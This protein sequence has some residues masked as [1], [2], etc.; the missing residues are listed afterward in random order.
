MGKNERIRMKAATAS[1]QWQQWA[2]GWG[3][4]GYQR[5]TYAS[6]SGEEL[7][8]YLYYRTPNSIIE[9]PEGTEVDFSQRF[10]NYPSTEWSSEY[11]LALLHVLQDPS[12]RVLVAYGSG[13]GTERNQLAD[14]IPGAKF[15]VLPFGCAKRQVAKT[16]SEDAGLRIDIPGIGKCSAYPACPVMCDG[17]PKYALWTYAEHYDS[18]EDSFAYLLVAEEVGRT[19]RYPP[20]GGAGP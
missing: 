10:G 4:S 8:R 12:G 20:D 11:V 19:L 17:M 14:V 13:Q 9:L 1:H 15:E 18:G 16:M 6:A 2:T 7:E 5:F 3:L